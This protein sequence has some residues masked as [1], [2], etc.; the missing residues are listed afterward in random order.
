MVLLINLCL[1]LTWLEQNYLFSSYLLKLPFV[2]VLS[3]HLHE[4]FVSCGQPRDA[5]QLSGTVVGRC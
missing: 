1:Y 3:Y 4:L 5:L 2:E